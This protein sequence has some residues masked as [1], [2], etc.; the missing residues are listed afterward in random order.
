MLDRVRL[1]D[2]I[3]MDQSSVPLKKKKKKLRPPN[4]KCFILAILYIIYRTS[5]F[6][7]R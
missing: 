5:I 7:G 2:F 6:D 3:S 1:Y 4:I